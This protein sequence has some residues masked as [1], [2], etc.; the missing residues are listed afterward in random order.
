MKIY[1]IINMIIY[2]FQ[3]NDMPTEMLV[4][5]TYEGCPIITIDCIRIADHSIMPYLN[6]ILVVLACL[7]N[8]LEFLSP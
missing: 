2:I 7:I 1:I 3:Q 8:R 5:F 6:F 4:L